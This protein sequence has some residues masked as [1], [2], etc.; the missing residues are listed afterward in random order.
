[1]RSAA[2]LALA[3]AGGAA[4]Q[5]LAV[6]PA[7][8]YDGHALVRVQL[9]AAPDLRLLEAIGADMWSHR[10]EAG[11]AGDFMIAPDRMDELD[12][13]GLDYEVLILDVQRVIDAESA[14]IRDGA[15]RGAGWYDEFKPLADIGDRL[16]ALA[17]ARPDIAAV[18]EAGVSLEGRPV[19]AL[20]IANGSAG[21]PACK[22]TILI[23]SCQHAREWITPMVCMYAAEQLLGAY[24]ADPGVTALIDGAEII[25]IPVVNPDGYEHT[26][27]RDRFWRKNRRDNGD[28]TFGVDLNRNWAYAWG[29][30]TGSSGNTG[31]Q[32]Y[33]GPEPFSEPE[34]RVVRDLALSRPRLAA[35]VDLHSYGQM[36]L[37]P[38]GYT[39]DLPPGHETFQMLGEEMQQIIAAVHGKHYVH[40][41][42][43]TTIYPV[44]GGITDWFWGDRGAH[45]FGVELRGPGFNPPPEQIL[46]NAQEMYPALVA[47][48]SWARLAHAPPGDFNHDASVDSL[49]VLAFV[50]AWSAGDGAAD[51]N[52]DGLLDIRDLSAFL[53]AWNAGC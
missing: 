1:M 8:R 2:V 13:S 5:P 3:L 47:F 25:F 33:R 23:D 35:H 10:V 21:D 22:P 18:F 37:A 44:S 15:G 49:D 28:G 52:G 36:L 16:D 12:A 46:P 41:P 26:W 29:S 40:G 24:G 42:I 31:S 9:R 32:T 17:A 51:F 39:S 30:N 14:R 19:R 50:G 34:S 48:A 6:G 45:P 7:A 11:G 4:A 20:R 43:Y 27:T 53:N 38:W